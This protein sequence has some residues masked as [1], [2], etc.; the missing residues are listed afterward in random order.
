MTSFYQTSV[1]AMQ[2]VGLLSEV[3]ETDPRPDR[4]IA[5]PLNG[6]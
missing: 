4:F 5:V 6:S 3:N 1:A 2:H